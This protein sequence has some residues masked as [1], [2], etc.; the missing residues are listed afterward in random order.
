MSA[1][2]DAD[3]IIVLEHGAIAEQGRHDEL[4]ARQGLYYALY[5]RQLLEESLEK[6]E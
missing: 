5:E 2:R 1:V 4:L 3:L 6:M